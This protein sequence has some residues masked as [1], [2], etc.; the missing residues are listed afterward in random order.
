[1]IKYS[2]GSIGVGAFWLLIV[3]IAGLA[4]YFAFGSIDKELAIDIDFND[5]N[6]NIE[7]FENQLALEPEVLG[8][9]EESEE[10]TEIEDSEN[11]TS[12][13]SEKNE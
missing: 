2:K 11:A 13:D 3:V 1:M 6:K 10:N 7:V 4:I 9:S 8:A 5:E 12:T